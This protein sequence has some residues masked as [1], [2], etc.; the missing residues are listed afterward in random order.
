MLREYSIFDIPLPPNF[1]M[2]RTI[3]LYPATPTPP[4]SLLGHRVSAT[5]EPQNFACFHEK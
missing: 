4:L 1:F 3:K 5:G 2:S